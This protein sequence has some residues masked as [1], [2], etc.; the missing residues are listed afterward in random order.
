MEAFLAILAFLFYLVILIGVPCIFGAITK[1]INENKGYDGGFAWG[2]WLGWIGVIV[3]ACKDPLPTYRPSSGNRSSGTTSQGRA[4]PPMANSSA[5]VPAGGWRCTCGRTYAAYVSSCVCGVSKQAATM[6]KPEAS[7]DSSSTAAP[8][9]QKSAPQKTS[10]QENLTLLR[11]YKQML[12][13]VV[14]TQEEFEN[15][16]KQLLGL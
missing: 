1:H 11:E 10:E 3:V 15:K 5:P 4:V 12:D 8:A 7:A 6:P 16:K 2:F 13:D 9:A 14:I